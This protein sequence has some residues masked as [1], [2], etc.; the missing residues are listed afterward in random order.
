MVLKSP[1]EEHT[2][3]YKLHFPYS[4][5]EAEYEGLLV[6]LK[7]AKKLGIKKLKVFRD[8]KLLI[9]QVGG[10]YRVNNVNLAASKAMVQE[11][12]KHFT[13]KECKVINR[14]ENKLANSLATLATKSMLKKEKMTLRVERQPSLIQVESCL[15]QDWQEPLLKAMT[16]GKYVTSKIA[17]KYEGLPQDQWG[18]LFFSE[19]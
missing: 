2:F 4:N 5:N 15:P 12:I 11:S 9:K 8:S 7:S 16:Q 17:I 19:E 18:F 3:A 1:G 10:T 6:G 13:S 14:N